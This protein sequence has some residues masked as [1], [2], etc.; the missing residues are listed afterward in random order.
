MKTSVL[1]IA[2]NE[3]RQIDKCLDSLLNQTQNPDEIILVA[4]NCTDKTISIAQG[5]ENIKTIK[6]DGPVGAVFP[7]VEGLQHISKESDIIL[8]LD[9]D[10]VAEENWVEELSKTL[11][12]NNNIL[13]GTYIKF[14]GDLFLW[15]SNIFNKNKCVTRGEEAT[16]WIWGGSF[17]FWNKDLEL[18]KN[19]L[20][21]TIELSRK[22]SLTRNPE[23]FFLAKFL[24]KEA[25]IEVTNKTFVTAQAKENSIF[26]SLKRN[27]INHYN[28]DI[29]EKYFLDLK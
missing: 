19:I 9:G 21:K 4:H 10:C 7:R 23:D 29:I 28:G 12:Q 8:F 6:Y 2:H 20:E 17:A 24:N 3:E 11:N 25:N 15:F 14:K 27:R 1:I 13:A 18:V 5:F 22:L 26:S 16:R